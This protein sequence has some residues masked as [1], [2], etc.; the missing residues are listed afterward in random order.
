MA[1]GSGR[2]WAHVAGVDAEDTFHSCQGRLGRCILV[3][4]I[5]ELRS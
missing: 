2:A 1:D 5:G 4:R 3:R